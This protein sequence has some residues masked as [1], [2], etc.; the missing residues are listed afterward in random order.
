MIKKII[1]LSLILT[2]VLPLFTFTVQASDTAQIFVN[3]TFDNYAI[4]ETLTENVT[5]TAGVDARVKNKKNTGF[6]KMLSLWYTFKD[7]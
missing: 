7:K 6:D 5:V 4:N 3:E 2:F 1:S